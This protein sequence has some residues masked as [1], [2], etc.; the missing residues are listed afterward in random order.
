MSSNYNGLTF[1]TSLE[2]QWAAFF[3]LAGWSWWVNP[4]SIDQWQPDFKV[5]F[6]CGHSECSGM[7]T[8]LV[9]VLPISSIEGFKKHPSQRFSYT[10]KGENG[11]HVADAGALFGDKPSVSI[12]EM[13]HGAGGGI[14]EVTNW[15]SNAE[16]LWDQA[17]LSVE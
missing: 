3:D 15:V 11:N 16:H 10:V 14:E 2:A 4:Q 9:S 8:L 5:Q 6:P 7:H 1:K 17:K 13:S 12:W